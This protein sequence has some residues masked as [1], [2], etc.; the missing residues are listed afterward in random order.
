[1]DFLI[2]ID[3]QIF[4][5]INN[6][7]NNLLDVLVFSI[8]WITEFG[9]IWIFLCLLILLFNKKG[10]RRK[11]I[12]IL[13]SLVISFLIV[14][15]FLKLSIFRT[16]PYS[17]FQGV[18]IL[19]KLWQDSSFPS[20]H[21]ASSAAAVVAIIYIYKIKNL[22]KILLFSGVILLVALSRVYS[23]MHYPS[24]VLAGAVIG[25]L[26]ALLVIAFDKRLA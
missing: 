17:V 21:V 12:I 1:M 10:K 7:H 4:F 11:I 9:L 6:I 20:G 5:L 13:A 15:V 23:G 25:I 22:W 2:Q 16:R 3:K 14:D 26:S 8:D 24:D 19:G 18:K